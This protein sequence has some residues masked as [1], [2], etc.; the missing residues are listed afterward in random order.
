MNAGKT[1]WELMDQ[2]RLPPELEVGE[3]LVASK[4]VPIVSATGSTRMGAIV[5]PKVAPDHMK[6]EVVMR[7]LLQ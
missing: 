5:G 4:D 2:V 7:P 1:V 6:Q 3:A